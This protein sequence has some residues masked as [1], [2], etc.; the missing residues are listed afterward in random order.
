MN[1][2]LFYTKYENLQVSE[3]NGNAFVVKNAAE[4]AVKGVEVDARWVIADNWDLTANIA[5]LDFEYQ[6]YDGAAP[7][8]RQSELLGQ[9]TQSLTGKTGAFAPDYSGNIAL[10]YEANVFSGY[11]LSANLALNFTDEFF[12]E[13]DLDP[14]AHQNAYEKINLRIGLLDA[15][16]KWSLSLLVNNLTDKSTFSQ[17][18]DVPV[19]SYAHRF[20]VE[21]PRSVLL[22]AAFFF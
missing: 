18:N 8:V 2:T 22:Q 5:L 4:T 9:A 15:D 10:N 17:A 13:Q 1:A 16:D 6:A 7:T 3:F 20:L 12:L 19:L 21:R 11:T 14:L